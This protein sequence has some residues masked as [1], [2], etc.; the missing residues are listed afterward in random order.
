MVRDC[1]LCFWRCVCEGKVWYATNVSPFPGWYDADGCG[2][3]MVTLAVGARVWFL[4][5]E[6]AMRHDDLFSLLRDPASDFVRWVAQDS[7][8]YGRVQHDL[9]TLVRTD[10]SSLLAD[11]VARRDAFLDLSTVAQMGAYTDIAELLYWAY[12]MH[13]RQLLSYM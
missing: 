8:L 6:V 4:E 9:L 7:A 1:L 5:K 2:A 3:S 11:R 13:C 12:E 10:G